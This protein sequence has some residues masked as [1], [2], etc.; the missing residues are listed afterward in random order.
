MN[1]PSHLTSQA[2]GKEQDDL[3]VHIGKKWPSCVVLG[4]GSKSS[5][6]VLYPVLR[7]RGLSMAS[8]FVWWF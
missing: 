5:F 1:T 8:A 2:N 6:L 3:M 4:P 7:T